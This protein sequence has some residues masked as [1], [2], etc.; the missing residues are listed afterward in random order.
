MPRPNEN[1]ILQMRWPSDIAYTVFVVVVIT[2]DEFIECIS[3]FCS[4]ELS[5]INSQSC[6]FTVILVNN[7]VLSKF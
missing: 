7:F 2:S 6:V 3:L 5:G 4:T 1:E